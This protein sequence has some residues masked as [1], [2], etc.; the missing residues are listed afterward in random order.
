[1]TAGIS[2]EQRPVLDVTVLGIPVAKGRPRFSGNGHAFTPDATRRAESRFANAVAT[3]CLDS[4]LS[5]I[6]GRGGMLPLKGALAAEVVF[7][8]KAKATARPDLDNLLKLVL[9]ALNG[10]VWNDDSQVISIK[11]KKIQN[12]ENPSTRLRVWKL[13][14]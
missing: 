12:A 11:T 1:M 7:V 14:E 13:E 3:H 5:V 10:I 2:T 8:T 4:G 9:D 6:G